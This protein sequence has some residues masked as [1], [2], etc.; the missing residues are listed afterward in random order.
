MPKVDTVTTRN[1]QDETRVIS[2]Q[3]EAKVDSATGIEPVD[4]P[5]FADLAELE[6][7]MNEPVE[8][9]L[10]E[11][12]EDH[13][14]PIVQLAVNGKNQFVIRGRTQTVKRKYVEVLCRAKAVRVS[15]SGRIRNDGEAQN[16]VNINKSL[17]YPFQVIQDRNPKGPAWL[18]QILAEG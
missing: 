7:F 2:G 6:K 1:G 15:A 16:I 14:E 10:Y 8:I 18:R 3:G 12:M 4:G 17:Q 11:G 9:F 13:D 5:G